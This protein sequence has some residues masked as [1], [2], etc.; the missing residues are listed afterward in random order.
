MLK[1]YVYG[2]VALLVVLLM[3]AASPGAADESAMMRAHSQLTYRV[4]ARKPRVNREVTGPVTDEIQGVPAEP[5]DSFVWDGEGSEPII[6]HAVLEIDPV[7]NTG[8]IKATWK[9]EYGSWTFEQMVFSP[10]PPHPTG[11]RVGPDAATT[12]LV[13]GDPVPVDVYLHGNTTAGGPVLPTLFNHLATWGTAEVTLNGEP[14]VNTYDGPTPDWIAHTMTSAG[15]R[16]ADG[17]VLEAV[18]TGFD[19]DMYYSPAES[20]NGLVDYDDMEFHLVFHDAPNPQSPT[21]NF[22]PPLAFFYH[23]TFEDVRLTITQK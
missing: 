1:R 7:S 15:A 12:V 6:G 5:V 2:A 13:E 4:V 8:W 11:L 20:D 21:N 9:D 18:E 17:E 19:E 16:N 23:L 22:P 10:L 3:T 14:F